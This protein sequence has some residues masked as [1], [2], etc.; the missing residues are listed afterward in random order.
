MAASSSSSPVAGE[1][2]SVRSSFDFP[3]HARILAVSFSSFPP[4]P[5]LFSVLVLIPD[6]DNYFLCMSGAMESSSWSSG[7]YFLLRPCKLRVLN[8]AFLTPPM[9]PS[10][11]ISFALLPLKSAPSNTMSSFQFCQVDSTFNRI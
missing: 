7:R 1:I 6:A 4:L 2:Q 9:S 11:R 10:L 3:E 8:A 5:R